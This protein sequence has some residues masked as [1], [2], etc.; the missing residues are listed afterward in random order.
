MN[1]D[2][3]LKSLSRYVMAIVCICFYILLGCSTGQLTGNNSEGYSLS[4][5]ASRIGKSFL[6]AAS[7][8]LTLV[9][10]FGAAATFFSGN[11]KHISD[12]A[13]SHTPVF[14]SREQAKSFSNYLLIAAGGS[15]ITAMTAQVLTN[16]GSSDG[17]C[18][19]AGVTF[20]SAG[21]AIGSTALVV[22]PLQI[23]SGRERPN[24]SDNLSFPSGHASYCTAI[25]TIASYNA[26]LLPVSSGYRIS[27]EAGTYA[28]AAGTAWA[29]VEAGKHYMSD[30]LA[31]WAIGHFFSQLACEAFLGSSADSIANKFDLQLNPVPGHL[32]LG[33]GFSMPLSL[34]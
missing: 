8:P 27:W 2:L 21:I 16:P 18:Y 12:W 15:A 1:Y 24:K 34:R 13:Y 30:V 29:R 6:R 28:L 11:D 20:A 23:N 31:G 3:F 26:A 25:A 33:V 7:S 17:Y 22:E 14:G 5:G 32:S 4:P 19:P 10:A 9:P